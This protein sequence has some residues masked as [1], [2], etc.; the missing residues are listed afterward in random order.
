MKRS[1]IAF[2]L[3]FAVTTAAFAGGQGESAPSIPL[4]DGFSRGQAA[5][6]DVQWQVNGDQLT[7]Q[8][9]APTTGW[10]AVGFDP[11]RMMAEANMI[12]GYVE[13]GT[14]TIADDYGTAATA[15]GR[16]TEN[17]GTNDII[18][19]D[20][21]ETEEGTQIS[22]TIPL[23]SGDATDKPLATGNSYKVIV[24]YGPDGSDNF[25]AYHEARGSI[26]MEL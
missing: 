7:V 21:R 5:G 9:S 6:V 16:D 18:S 17:G 11:A 19:V 14:V 23:D 8:M 20:G 26:T 4:R 22:F 3:I 2:L 25:D 15:H 10:I 13:N 1:L 12:I 24:A